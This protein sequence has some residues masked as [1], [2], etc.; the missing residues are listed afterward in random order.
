MLILWTKQ[1][2]NYQ[3]GLKHKRSQTCLHREVQNTSRTSLIKF[4]FS[5]C[6]IFLIIPW[7]SKPK[8]ALLSPVSMS[9]MYSHFPADCSWAVFM[10]AIRPLVSDNCGVNIFMRNLNLLVS[11]IMYVQVLL[12]CVDYISHNCHF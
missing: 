7:S 9:R 3:Q 10:V 6:T 11:T 8:L 4:M 5:N 12:L 1:D 2:Q